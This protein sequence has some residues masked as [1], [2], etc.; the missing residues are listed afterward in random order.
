MGKV[1]S[2]SVFG[3]RLQFNVG[4]VANACAWKISRTLLAKVQ[5]PNMKPPDDFDGTGLSKFR[6]WW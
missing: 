4:N 3:R 1:F 2:G 5:A 6:S